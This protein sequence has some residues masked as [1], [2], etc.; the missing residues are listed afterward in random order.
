MIG[1][2]IAA[3]L[4]AIL[5]VAA[6]WVRFSLVLHQSFS[7]DPTTWGD[8]GSFVGGILGP[9]LSFISLFFIIRSLRLQ[10]EANEALRKEA[11][12]NEKTDQLKSFSV[13]FFN[14]IGSQKT[15]LE[16]FSI[17]FEEN[18]NTIVRH[19]VDAVMKIED[20]VKFLRKKGGSDQNISDYLDK[21]DTRDQIFGI[22]RAFYISVKIISERLGNKKM[23]SESE[24]RDF[25]NTLINFTDFSQL[26]MIIMGI[27]FM[28]SEAARYLKSNNEFV[29]VLTAANL[30]LNPY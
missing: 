9:L 10:N 25:M 24:R 29:S 23:F 2:I 6:Y 26:R 20:D 27:Q 30:P 15:L 13:L 5:V 7:A 28:D 14:M 18:G 1:Y 3:A 19:G 4:S 21:I 22:L 11:E 17:H 12:G 8:F 16:K